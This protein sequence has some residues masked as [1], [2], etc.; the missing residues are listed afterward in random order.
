MIVSLFT[1]LA[2]I[3][4]FVAAQASLLGKNETKDESSGPGRLP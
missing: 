3:A 1:A 2:C 4:F